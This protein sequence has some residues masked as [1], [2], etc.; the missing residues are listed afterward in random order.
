MTDW[1]NPAFK[2]SE[3]T[4]KKIYAMQSG[5]KLQSYFIDRSGRIVA[6]NVY[7]PKK[8]KWEYV[9]LDIS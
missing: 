9:V 1:L 2:I 7:Y 8:R 5:K 6:H 4:K 3:T